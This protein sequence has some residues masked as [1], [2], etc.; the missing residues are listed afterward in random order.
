M[1][2]AGLPARRRFWASSPYSLRIFFSSSFMRTRPSPPSSTLQENFSR[3]TPA[4]ARSAE[5]ILNDGAYAERALVD[6]L[7]EKF[8]CRVEN[9]G[10]RRFLLNEAEKNIRKQFG[11]DALH[12]L[13]AGNPAAAMALGGLL[14]YLY[15]TQKTDLPHNNDLDLFLIHI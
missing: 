7:R 8:S 6:V 10:E 5:A 9:G 13:P 1:A 12:Q 4:R 2:D 3:S 11:E 14:N 15:E